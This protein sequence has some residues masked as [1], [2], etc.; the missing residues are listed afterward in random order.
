M[1]PADLDLVCLKTPVTTD[2][3]LL[4]VG[5]QGV[6]LRVF[7]G[8]EALAVEFAEPFHTVATVRSSEAQ[9]CHQ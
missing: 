9:I 5:S 1:A 2:D 8:G 6:V 3:G 7:E 4:P